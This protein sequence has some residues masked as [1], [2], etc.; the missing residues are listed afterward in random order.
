MHG[1]YVLLHASYILL[2]TLAMVGDVFLLQSGNFA[3]N[4]ERSSLGGSGSRTPQ[5]PREKRLCD[6]GRDVLR[7]L[8]SSSTEQH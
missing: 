2:S 3:G 4:I 1:S 6:R 8:S 7:I 5:V